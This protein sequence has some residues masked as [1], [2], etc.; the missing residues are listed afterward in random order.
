ME[1]S[2]EPYPERKKKSEKLYGKSK[3]KSI[4]S[5]MS[6]SP[7]H[8]KFSARDIER[9]HSGKMDPAEMHALEKAAL[10]DPFLADALEGYVFTSTPSE[11]LN[12][13]RERLQQKESE[14]KAVPFFFINYNW[15]KI[16]ALFLILAGSGWFI[17]RMSGRSNDTIALEKVVDAPAHD[18]MNISS[19]TTQSPAATDSTKT[20]GEA[21]PG[22]YKTETA[23]GTKQEPSQAAPDGRADLASGNI[24]LH[25]NSFDKIAPDNKETST[26]NTKQFNATVLNNASGPSVRTNNMSRNLSNNNFNLYDS[27][28]GL[29]SKKNRADKLFL[30]DSTNNLDV[31]LQPLKDSSVAE[32][33][34]ASP[35]AFGKRKYFAKPIVIVDTLEP[36]EGYTNLDDYIVNNLRYPEELRSKPVSGDVQLSFEVDKDGKPTNITVEKSLC[37][38]CDEEAIRLL[39]EGP[40]W[41]KTKKK[42]GK[43]TIHF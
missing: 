38:K 39:K 20:D 36:E 1:Q 4:D 41:K 33:V 24:V 6:Q 2:E 11:D 21:T 29:A 42:K 12:R 25:Q 18:S 23:K 43:I 13:L 15:L 17:Y 27:T 19:Q 8:N 10:D 3:N 32:V 31:V 37:N 5:R 14:R 9:Y 34:V 22:F 26:A 30:N 28:Q 40:K 16:A 7:D 35:S